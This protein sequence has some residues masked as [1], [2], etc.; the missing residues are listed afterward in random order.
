VVL[1]EGES[2]WSCLLKLNMP[3]KRPPRGG[4][5]LETK[6]GETYTAT[7][8]NASYTATLYNTLQHPHSRRHS[9]LEEALCSALHSVAVYEA[10]TATLYN[11]TLYKT[12]QH[13][14]SRRQSRCVSEER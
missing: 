2:S 1:F 5:L 10:Y 6:V 9:V 7:L 12:L 14:H 13:L 11:T 3:K 8:Y 4:R